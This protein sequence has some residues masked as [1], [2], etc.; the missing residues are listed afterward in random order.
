MILSKDRPKSFQFSVKIWETVTGRLL[1]TLHA[2]NAPLT[3]LTLDEKAN[4]GL[5]F[6]CN[7]YLCN[8]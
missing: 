5:F 6:S 1:Y 4:V 2:H 8:G 7:E 3:C